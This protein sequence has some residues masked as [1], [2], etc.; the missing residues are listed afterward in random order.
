MAL[1]KTDSFELYSCAT[2]VNLTARIGTFTEEKREAEEKD[3]TD[4]SHKV[5]VKSKMRQ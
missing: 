5:N 4:R 3:K 1:S 2:I